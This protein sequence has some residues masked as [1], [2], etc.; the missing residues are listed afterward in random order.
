M[1]G[2][3]NKFAAC[4]LLSAVLIS[5]AAGEFGSFNVFAE[6]PLKAS[7]LDG[8]IDPVPLHQYY[9]TD[10]HTDRISMRTVTR[11]TPRGATYK[12]KGR[13]GAILYEKVDAL[14]GAGAP[15]KT[16][17]LKLN[18][19]CKV[20]VVLNKLAD[21]GAAT[22]TPN[23][24]HPEGYLPI[25]KVRH[26][27]GERKMVKHGYAVSTMPTKVAGRNEYLLEIPPPHDFEVEG[28]PEDSRA[29]RYT[30]LFVHPETDDA[31]AAPQTPQDILDD[32]NGGNIEPHVRCPG[33]LHDKWRTATSAD[34]TDE[35]NFENGEQVLHTT[36]HPTIDPVY[37]CSYMHDHGSY[38]GPVYK[39]AYT[40]TAWHT[41]DESNLIDQRQNES[42]AGFKTFAIVDPTTSDH[43]IITVHMELGNPR[44]FSTSFHTIHL[45]IFQVSGEIW[46]PKVE[47]N[48]KQDYGFA[49]TR[50]RRTNQKNELVA[51]TEAEQS[52]RDMQGMG[53]KNSRFREFNVG[54]WSDTCNFDMAQ[55][56]FIDTAPGVGKRAANTGANEHWV[57]SLNTCGS[58]R[59]R[60]D[61]ARPATGL[62]TCENGEGKVVDYLQGTSIQRTLS[63]LHSGL[64]VNSDLCSFNVPAGAGHPIKFYTDSHFTQIVNGPGKYH[65]A[66]WMAPG[67]SS[68]LEAG[69][70]RPQNPWNGAYIKGKAIGSKFTNIEGWSV[71]GIGN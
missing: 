27:N 8:S 53:A 46:T 9:Y 66:Q 55:G 22:D 70:Y 5:T 45:A 11:F 62:E 7:L 32:P 21:F 57:T 23:V 44:R 49:A 43:W 33:A 67:F 56:D 25:R 26:V 19:N 16:L 18:K 2:F 34:T 17:T 20:I 65:L 1:T 54:S 48:Y 40:H 13:Q 42:D 24:L 15:N 58:S 35:H 41:M 51:L 39:P 37:Y 12:Q 31:F 64:T 4:G 60:I 29:T 30:I 47:L 38:P 63:S 59:F 61:V 6:H 52:I 71:E 14:I 68:T 10:V 69:K 36:W 28:M 3:T 50:V